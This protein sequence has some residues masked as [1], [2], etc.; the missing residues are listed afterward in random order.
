MR[1]FLKFI[2]DEHMYLLYNFVIWVIMIMKINR[3]Y[4]FRLYP[5]K[6][7]EVLIHKTFG[8]TRFVYNYCLYLKRNNKYLTKFDLIKELPGLK[9]DHSFLKEVD[10]CSL[11]NAITD[12]MVGF[13][14]L[15]KRLYAI[16]FSVIA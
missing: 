4:Q 6:E 14:L 5:T 9:K 13:G 2:L 16:I 11:Q 12:L 10:S 8:C 7:Q 1:V 15:G 3:A